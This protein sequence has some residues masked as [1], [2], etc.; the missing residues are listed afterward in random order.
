MQKLNPKK[1][2]Y[3][4]GGL[5]HLIGVQL[6]VIFYFL[7]GVTNYEEGQLY[8]V[9]NLIITR[10]KLNI[11]CQEKPS[12]AQLS[13]HG[14]SEGRCRERVSLAAPPCRHSP[15][16]GFSPCAPARAVVLVCRCS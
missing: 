12:V 11:H 7:R 4:F 2:E 6:A 1:P 8:H 3:V 13:E 16:G 14:L 9:G 5:F 10:G 15:E